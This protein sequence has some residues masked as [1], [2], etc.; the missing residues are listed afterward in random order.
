VSGQRYTVLGYKGKQVR[1][2]IHAADLVSALWHFFR[3]P[4]V[5]E[6]Y[7]IGGGRHSQC[8]VLEA[9]SICERQTGRPMNWSYSEDNRPGD[10]IW[11]I[12]DVRKFQTH[13]PEWRYGYNLEELIGEIRA[14]LEDRAGSQAS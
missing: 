14:T 13:Y 7:N 9:I 12:S 6:V 5:A 8:S 1:D 2:N 11:W 3:N 10:H 4:R